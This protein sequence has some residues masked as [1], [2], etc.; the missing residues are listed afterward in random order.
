MPVETTATADFVT[1]VGSGEI[2]SEPR[3][4]AN[5]LGARPGSRCVQRVERMD[6]TLT[7]EE[8]WGLHV[9]V[10]GVLTPKEF[11]DATAIGTQDPRFV[12]LRYVILNYLDVTCHSFDVHDM[13]ELAQANAILLGAMT[14]NPD[15]VAV[16]VAPPEIL[17]LTRLMAT[18]THMRWRVGY[19]ESELKGFDWLSAQSIVFRQRGR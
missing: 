19:F 11:F 5:G 10:R 14:S 18:I 16:V 2:A 8:P 7:W 17:E 15:I 6:Y 1:G 13:A 4:S 9:H 3:Q 12:D